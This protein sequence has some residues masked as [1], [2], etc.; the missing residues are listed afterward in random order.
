MGAVQLVS[1]A[2]QRTALIWL[3]NGGEQS[4]LGSPV[5]ERLLESWS[6]WSDRREARPV[7]PA[8]RSASCRPARQR[9]CQ[10]LTFCRETPSW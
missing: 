6:C 9:V 3:V 7:E 5:P 1:L 4:G 10:R 2:S 8:L